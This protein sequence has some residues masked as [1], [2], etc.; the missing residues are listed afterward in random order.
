MHLS[1]FFFQKLYYFVS[2]CLLCSS[3]IGLDLD[4][5][6]H[7]R[8]CCQMSPQMTWVFLFLVSTAGAIVIH[9]YYNSIYK[10]YPS[11]THLSIHSTFCSEAHHLVVF[12]AWKLEVLHKQVRGCLISYN[13]Q[14][15]RNCNCIYKEIG[16][17]LTSCARIAAPIDLNGIILNDDSLSQSVRKV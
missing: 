4:S 10:G 14:L 5:H 6:S 3:V 8:G 16:G 12:F 15:A 7:S 2:G 13:F 11:I 17:H 9:N 1:V